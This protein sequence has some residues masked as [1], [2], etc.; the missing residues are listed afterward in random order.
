MKENE[1]TT[2]KSRELIT[3]AGNDPKMP[4]SLFRDIRLLIEQSRHRFSQMINSELVALY[5]KSGKCTRGYSERE[6]RLIW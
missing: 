5:W 3:L 1:K 2:S 6:A 4:G